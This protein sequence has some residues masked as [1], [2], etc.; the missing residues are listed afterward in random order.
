[1]PMIRFD[2]QLADEV[3][4]QDN[5]TGKA[6]LRILGKEGIEHE[7]FAEIDLAECTMRFHPTNNSASYGALLSSI[8]ETFSSPFSAGLDLDLSMWQAQVRATVFFRLRRARAYKLSLMA[9]AGRSD[10]PFEFVFSDCVLGPV[11]IPNKFNSC[12]FKFNGIENLVGGGLVKWE[13]MD[14]KSGSF[15][16]PEDIRREKK[17]RALDFTLAVVSLSRS[18]LTP[19]FRV[20]RLSI[21][22]VRF[23]KSVSQSEALDKIASVTRFAGILQGQGASLTRVSLYDADNNRF[24]L[25]ARFTQSGCDEISESANNRGVFFDALPR[26]RHYAE[27]Y[28][29][30]PNVFHELAWLPH[31]EGALLE[32]RVVS[33]CAVAESLCRVFRG[34]SFLYERNKNGNKVKKRLALLLTHISETTAQY[35]RE[36]PDEDFLEELVRHRNAKAHE[37]KASFTGDNQ[38]DARIVQQNEMLL[39]M[40]RAFVLHECGVSRKTILK[41]L[42]G[43]TSFYSLRPKNP[44]NTT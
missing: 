5:F 44:D 4:L 18:A 6:L 41:A 15:R 9:L 30:A 27:F 20:K 39:Q 25:R 23:A 12:N 43:A 42:G 10:E 21:V 38:D 31:E 7:G 36:V 40:L 8:N 29:R 34:R 11:P 13:N 19:K 35:F 17:S 2:G 37:A 32:D 22:R 26:F 16:L 3:L 14:A 1:M 24:Q 28:K 33:L